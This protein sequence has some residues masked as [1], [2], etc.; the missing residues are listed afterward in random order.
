[1]ELAGLAVGVVGLAGLFR[2][3]LA[4][5]DKVQS[6]RSSGPDMRVLDIRFKAAKARF[7]QWGQGVG[8]KQGRLLDDHHSA[9]DD[10]DRSSAVSDLLHI[11]IK[12]ICDATETRRELHSW[13]G[14]RSPNEHYYDS[15]QKRLVGTYDWILNRPA[16]LHWLSP[17]FSAGA[18]AKL[19]WIN[20][21]AGFGKT[22]LCARV[23]EHLFSALETPVAH[24]FF[25]CGL[26]SREDPFVAIQSWISQVVSR[27][28]GAFEHVRQRWEADLD[29]VATHATAITLFTQLLHVVPGCTFVADGLDECTYLD[30]SS[31]S[32]AKL[33]YTILQ[34]FTDDARESF[35]KYKIS[36]DGVRSDTAAFSWDIVDRKLPNTG[37]NVRSTLSEESLRRWM[38]KKQLQHAI[39]ETLTGLDCLY[40]QNWTRIIRYGERKRLHAFA[41]LRWAAFALRPITV[42][43][44]AEAVLIDECEDLPLEDLP[45]AVDDD[46]INSEIVCLCS[47]L[48]EVRSESLDLSAGQRTVHLPHFTVRQCLLCNLPI[49]GCIRQNERLAYTSRR[50]RTVTPAI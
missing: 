19:L 1:M 45:D 7:E 32:V 12:A 15:V 37:D 47:S 10:K 25:S 36:P 40:N 2:S 24:V 38:D 8:I 48:L 17:A 14:H 6:Y 3:C 42:C 23:V 33:L 22:I 34:A 50:L 16:F 21:P 31:T 29:P 18:N 35:A 27:H 44:I 46:Y 11:I 4:A 43:E 20:G 13:L 39:E 9:L 5:V 30:N 28:E 26:K 49:P 41:L